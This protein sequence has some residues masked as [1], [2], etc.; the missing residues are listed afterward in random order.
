[1]TKNNENKTKKVSRCRTKQPGVYKNT[2]TGK[3]DVK[4]CYSVVNPMTTQ[5]E[6]KQKWIY[7]INSYTEAVQMLQKMKGNRF[8]PNNKEF[9]LED[10]L[11]LWK[12]KAQ[13]NQYSV[14]TVRNTEQQFNMIIKFMSPKIAINLITEEMYLSLIAKCREYGYSE[15]T[16]WNINACI[17]KL[18]N[19]AYKNRYIAE[20][21]ITFWDSPHINQGTKRYVIAY[22][23]FE[24]L[25]N[26]FYKS[27]YMKLGDNPY[28]KYYFLVNLLYFTGVRIG[29]AIALTYADFELYSKT[30]CG[31]KKYMRVNVTKSYNS[32]YKLTKGVKNLKKRKIP[33]PQRLI[34]IYQ[35]MLQEHLQQG[36][37]LNDKIFPWQHNACTNMIKNAST[38]LEM[39]GY[40]C[41]DFRHT[42]ISNLIRHGV[43]LSVIEAVSGDTQETIFKRY[44]HMF[45]GDE[46]L[47]LAVFEEL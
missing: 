2:S 26:Y 41:H 37:T 44:S 33:V 18:I 36:G 3:Y 8:V 7:N 43:P 16:V 6:Y 21:P 15:E 46:E 47:V 24:R 17:R 29:E 30:P 35:T 40:T 31:K 4:Y 28:P 19:L 1:M 27:K 39:R 10:A 42:Y 32:V 12:D 25:S 20:N 13:A 9:T 45:Q 11:Q 22:E 23:D 5:K 38:S 14:M 34:M